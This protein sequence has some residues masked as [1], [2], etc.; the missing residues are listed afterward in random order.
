MSIDERELRS[1]LAESDTS[2]KFPPRG[3]REGVCLRR[4]AVM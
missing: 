2:P 3:T 1:R 4:C